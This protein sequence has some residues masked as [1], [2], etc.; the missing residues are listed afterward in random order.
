MEKLR[1]VK[2]QSWV[3]TA[4]AL[5]TR[6]TR[7]VRCPCCGSTSLK[8]KDVE[9]GLGYDRGVQ[10]YMSCTSCGAFSGVSLRRAGELA[11]P[12]LMAAE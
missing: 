1:D 12:M 10:R 5:V 4:E 2:F 8:V 7:E 11:P 3:E 6:S 9:Y